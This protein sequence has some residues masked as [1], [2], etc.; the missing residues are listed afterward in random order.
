[1]G[2]YALSSE[3][4][5]VL[6]IFV[7]VAFEATASYSFVQIKGSHYCLSSVLSSSSLVTIVSSLYCCVDGAFLCIFLPFLS[8]FHL[9]VTCP[10]FVFQVFC[11]NFW[12][13]L[14]ITGHKYIINESGR[15]R[16][17]A[18]TFLIDWNSNLI[19]LHYLY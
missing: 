15:T 10:I 7:N 11:F 8:L 18:D 3:D 19:E 12:K 6:W 13:K 16:A 2:K 14:V 1:M 9:P 4:W 5:R 17:Q